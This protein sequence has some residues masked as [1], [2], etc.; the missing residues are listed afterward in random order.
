MRVDELVSPGQST[1]RMQGT[2]NAANPQAQT[3]G[4]SNPQAQAP[5]GPNNVNPNQDPKI[6]MGDDPNVINQRRR[7]IDLQIKTLQDTIKN[8]QEQLKNLQRQKSSM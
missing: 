1:T 8:Q 2:N 6:P 4:G 5:G 3:S 7:Q